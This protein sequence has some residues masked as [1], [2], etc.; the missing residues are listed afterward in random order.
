MGGLLAAAA[1]AGDAGVQSMNQNIEQANKSDLMKQQSDLEYNKRKLLEDYAVQLQNQQ[2][3][4]MVARVGSAKQGLI[5][6][7]MSGQ[8]GGSDAAV[9][10]ADAGNTDAPLSDDQ[11]AVIEQ[12]KSAVVN[13]LNADPKIAMQAAINTGDISP[14]KA[15]TMG[16]SAEINQMKMD[17]LLA[18]ANDKNATMKEIA[19]VRA[20]SLKYGYELRLQAAQERK[21]NGK[22]DTATGRMMITSEDANIRASTSQLGMLQR[23]LQDIPPPK[24]GKASAAY[25]DLIAQMNNIR[26]DIKVSQANKAQY[27]QTMGILPPSKPAA[28]ATPAAPAKPDKPFNPADFQKK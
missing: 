6:Q 19:D 8:F 24:P 22:I 23:Q 10:D 20:D 15:A 1:A 14:E 28:S 5:Q 27:L 4:A 2:R 26:E 21:A 18:R 16:Q 13:K 12:A 17:N 9:A 7:A 3:E 11:R 25:D